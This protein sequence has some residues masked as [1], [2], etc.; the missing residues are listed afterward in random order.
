[1]SLF[2]DRQLRLGAVEA[3]ALSAW[4]VPGSGW[5]LVV[6]ARC[7]QQLWSGVESVTYDALTTPEL[8][9]AVLAQ[10]EHELGL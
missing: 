8:A 7:A 5:R 6:R 2:A 4:Y 3:L 9:D 10:L 1:M